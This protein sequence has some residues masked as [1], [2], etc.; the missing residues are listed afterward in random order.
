M[1]QN[2]VVRRPQFFDGQG[3]DPLDLNRATSAARAYLNDVVLGP[4]LST[5]RTVVGP[6]SLSPDPTS[7][8]ATVPG[9]YP[10]LFAHGNG[11]A[12][13]NRA[14]NRAVG[15]N[16]GALYYVLPGLGIDGSNPKVVPYFLQTDEI[17][18]TLDAGDA[19][20]PRFDAI[21]VR[22]TDTDGP[23]ETRD[24]KDAVGV[25]TSQPF[26]TSKSST[27][28][29][30]V[31]KGTPAAKPL[32]PAPPD[33][34][35]AFWG[36]WWV[37]KA[38]GAASF[39]TIAYAAQG[40]SNVID[41]RFPIG[42]KK[43]V[44]TPG[45][46][47]YGEPGRN[48]ATNIYNGNITFSGVGT[49]PNHQIQCACPVRSGRLM[50]YGFSMHTVSQGINSRLTT[51]FIPLGADGPWSRSFY[52]GS[53]TGIVGDPS[54][55]YGDLDY[56]VQLRGGNWFAA[57]AV[58]PAAVTGSGSFQLL[59]LWANGFSSE[60]EDETLAG[61]SYAIGSTGA[62]A[63]D[64]RPYLSLKGVAPTTAEVVM[65]CIWDIAG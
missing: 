10:T 54:M 47:L 28:E 29:F 33:T 3:V 59:P 48:A 21:F 24:F 19:S 52:G 5:Y 44:V 18:A 39:K 23:Q 58:T 45:A 14:G 31:V 25:V 17:S 64:A 12:P 61:G 62:A 51:Q 56:R 34:T 13:R 16:Q 4:L 43:Y 63:I 36:A 41:Y 38:F 8:T 2:N 9:I 30:V 26:F 32:M 6:V 53:S 65:G 42:L 57:D 22:I 7:T 37:S 1:P 60:A 15:C 27:L 55:A 20:N 11:G 49:W 46:G 35:W 50:S 40:A